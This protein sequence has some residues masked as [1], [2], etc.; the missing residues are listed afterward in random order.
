MCVVPCDDL[1][2]FVQ[3]SLQS[4]RLEPVQPDLLITCLVYFDILCFGYA[5]WLSRLSV[6]ISVI[7]VNC[8]LCVVC[9]TNNSIKAAQDNQCYAQRHAMI[10]I[11]TKQ[12]KD[13][14]PSVNMYAVQYFEC[15]IFKR[16]LICYCD[17]LR[18]T[19]SWPFVNIYERNGNINSGVF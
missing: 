4:A 15:F 17:V 9:Y 12:S 13:G 18:Y 8:L 10:N 2:L 6:R 11:S 16:K 14:V 3:R 7:L 19:L 1:C 5:N